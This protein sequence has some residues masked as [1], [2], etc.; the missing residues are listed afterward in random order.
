MLKEVLR[1]TTEIISRIWSP[2]QDLNVRPSVRKAGKLSPRLTS[3]SPP[4][5]PHGHS[6]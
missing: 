4:G 2:G 6:A 5:G 3:D 1:K